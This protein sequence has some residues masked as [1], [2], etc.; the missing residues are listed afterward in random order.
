MKRNTILSFL[1]T[2]SILL[3]LVVFMYPASADDNQTVLWLSADWHLD[4]TDQSDPRGTAWPC[5]WGD[6]LYGNAR[7]AVNDTRD[8]DVD[9]AWVVGDMLSWHDQGS[10]YPDP[11]GGPFDISWE[12]FGGAWCNLTVNQYKN[13]TIGNHDG[14][15]WN[16]TPY[17]DEIGIPRDAGSDS[18]WY[19][20]D[21]GNINGGGVRII[22]M[23]D[24]ETKSGGDHTGNGEIGLTQHTWVN[25]SIASAYASGLSVFIFNH[26]RVAESWF[27]LASDTSYN[28][29]T[30][31]PID[32]IMNYW[33][34]QGTPISFFACGHCH[35][36]N[37]NDYYTDD[38]E[39]THYGT[40]C[41]LIGSIAYYSSISVGDKR[42]WPCSRYLNF[43]DGSTTVVVKAYNHTSNE[44]FPTNEFTF[45]LEYAWDPLPE[46][47]EADGPVFQSINGQANNTI[48]QENNRTFVWSN[49]SDVNYYEL[50]IGNS[51]SEGNVTDIFL[52]LS[53]INE[54]NYGINFTD[55]G[56]NIEF[57]LSH[58]YNIS[59]Y[60][61]H[62]YQ[63]R[64]FTG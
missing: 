11:D 56:G 28:G 37:Q 14:G 55:S 20:Y 51:T 64:A 4:I 25:D 32:D 53:D 49:I 23:A 12:R 31:Y 18:Q 36:S 3:S 58:E 27:P 62:Y 52:F 2:A 1:I 57:I 41:C 33:N 47:E 9:Y 60:G 38:L 6:Y 61:Y 7:D 8:M 30:G 46:G 22:C 59:Y 45:E 21:I 50:R 48:L 29:M 35:Q 13:W 54:T 24:E 34:T 26:Q 16:V 43:T 42:H 5:D 63:V 40:S 44:F 10:G 39:E 17:C 19:Y 15:W